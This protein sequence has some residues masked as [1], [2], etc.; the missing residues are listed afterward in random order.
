MRS[1][2]FV[3][4]AALALCGQAWAADAGDEDIGS[5]IRPKYEVLKAGWPHD[6]QGQLIYG[7]VMLD[8]GVDSKAY[9]TDCKVKSSNPANAEL[10]RAALKLAP[11]F[12]AQAPKAT[13]RAILEIDVR[14]DEPADWLKWPD[15][16]QLMAVFPAKALKDGISGRAVIKC[17]VQAN[18]LTR[19]CSILTEDRPGLGFSPAAVALS[20]TFLFKPAVRNGTPVEAEVTIPIGFQIGEAMEEGF[21]TARIK[22]SVDPTTT[23]LSEAIWAKTPSVSQILAEIDKKVGDKF[24]DGQVVLQCRMD[25]TTGELNNCVLANASP[26][27]AQFKDVAKALAPRFQAD[28][29]AL[30]GIKNRVVVNLAFAFPDMSSP[31]WRKRY[32]THPRWVQTISPDRDKATFPEA[33]AKAGLKTGS[34]TVDC[35]AA[36]DGRLGACQV[37]RE[38]TPNVGF[39]DMAVQIAQTFVANP[40]DEDGLP[41][42]GAHVRMPIQMDYD[43]PAEP[44][45]APVAKP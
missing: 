45:P 39:G 4:V 16:G 13:K 5:W 38:S 24:A 23:V 43:P 10:E 7:K 42:D 18:G 30:A 41:V 11:L 14:Y 40:W 19:A 44:P 6:A 37:V 31:D 15:V 21:S 29:A 28:P 26:G 20:K 22:E 27:M 12:K 36:P 33:A 35:V 8:C 17:F 32:L 25:K 3:A 34:A 2:S 9:A 1:W